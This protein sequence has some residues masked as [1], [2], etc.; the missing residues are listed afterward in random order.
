MTQWGY[1]AFHV[2]GEDRGAEFAY[3]VAWHTLGSH[4]LLLLLRNASLRRLARQMV[5][6]YTRQGECAVRG[7]KSMAMACPILMR[8]EIALVTVKEQEL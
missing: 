5:V 1:Q 7:K 6:L 2:H 4:A 3:V 8:A